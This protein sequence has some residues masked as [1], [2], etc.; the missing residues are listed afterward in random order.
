MDGGSVGAHATDSNIQWRTRAVASGGLGV[1]GRLC[2]RA[3]CF[4]GIALAGSLVVI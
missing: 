2:C 4:E 1:G 3:R